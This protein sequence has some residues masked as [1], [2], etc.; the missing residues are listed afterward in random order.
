MLGDAGRR[1][2]D[3]ECMPTTENRPASKWAIGVELNEEHLG[4]LRFASGLANARGDDL[5]LGVHVLPCLER[6]HP[7]VNQAQAQLTRDQVAEQVAALLAREGLAEANTR[8]ELIE[9]DDVERGLSQASV[10]LGVDA[11]IV[12][13]RAKRDEDP[14]VRLGEVT[15]RL[16][17]KLPVPILVTPPDFGAPGDPGMGHGPVIVGVD[18]AEHCKTAI[19]FAAPIA[20]RLGRPLLLA[21]G[22]SVP[23]W[24]I[25]YMPPAGMDQLR[26]QARKEAT[27]KL[28][29]WVDT[30]ELGTV[31]VGTHVFTGDPARQLLELAH[32][33]D[34]ALLVTGSRMLGP[35]ER[36]FLSSISSELAAAARCPVAV[37]PGI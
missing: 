35:V 14:L 18:L 36:L 27:T 34:A 17:R 1:T 5:M 32:A 16:L 21:H 12:G 15:R 6:L 9:D 4:P 10:R 2:L 20:A 30:L 28:R 24:G 3:H 19:E 25:S 29:E 22:T 37:V 26:A 33:G 31:E 7:M 13:R 23:S 8:V 11:L